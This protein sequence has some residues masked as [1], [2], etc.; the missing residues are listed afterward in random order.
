VTKEHAWNG[1]AWVQIASSNLAGLEDVDVATIPPVPGDGLV[2]NGVDWIAGAPVSQGIIPL[3]SVVAATTGPITIAAPPATLDGITP[4]AGARVLIKDQANAVENGIYTWGPLTRAADANTEGSL[5]P[6]NS[7]L[8][9]T[10]TQNGGISFLVALATAELPWTPGTDQDRWYA[11]ISKLDMQA[12]A[13]LVLTGNSLDVG[14]GSGVVIGP[15][16]VGTELEVVVQPTT[17]PPAPSAG[18]FVL[19]GDPSQAVPPAG[20]THME[21]ITAVQATT[22]FVNTTGDT[23]TGGLT[24]TGTA[25]GVDLGPGLM[26]SGP[27]GA[28]DLV[29]STNGIPRW[30]WRA[31]GTAEA[32]ADA[33]SNLELHA[34][35]DDGTING[36]PVFLCT[37]S[38]GVVSIPNVKAPTLLANAARWADGIPRFA[39]TAERDAA[40]ATIGGA[41]N[42]MQC[43]TTDTF[44]TWQYRNGWVSGA[45]LTY[46]IGG[47]AVTVDA[48]E[49]VYAGPLVI[50]AQP[51]NRVAVVTSQ[52]VSSTIPAS[53]LGLVARIKDGAVLLG[54]MRDT[55]SAAVETG[56]FAVM[57]CHYP[58]PAGTALS[59]TATIGRRTGTVTI[60]T[61]T[62]G[63]LNWLA[64]T[65]F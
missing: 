65:L 24:I 8:V 15:D 13:G 25:L 37:R 64:A 54:Q 45:A 63:S 51:R 36:T 9:T 48:T 52:S 12:G 29:L 31:N 35:K 44:T 58:V 23:M 7:V 22:D 34:R 33:G 26:V 14:A 55:L 1:T 41:V 3:A 19:W 56:S 53:A 38:T 60:T 42:G 32:G 30:V 16:T 6:G 62:D 4:A 11:A 18:R 27:G 2:W 28:R 20:H 21:Y 49:R 43:V 46:K 61:V 17:P 5:V 39:T 50:P 10:G 57:T 59:L 47:L 40:Y